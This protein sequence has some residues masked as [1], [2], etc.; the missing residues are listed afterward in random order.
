MNSQLFIFP[1]PERLI[2]HS[3]RM[4]SRVSEKKANLVAICI[5]LVVH[6]LWEYQNAV[7]TRMASGSLHARAESAAEPS[8]ASD[9]ST[10]KRLRISRTDLILPSRVHLSDVEQ[11]RITQWVSPLCRE[12]VVLPLDRWRLTKTECLWLRQS[13]RR[14]FW[15]LLTYNH[16]WFL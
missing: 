15:R 11:L 2:W 7:R 16:I 5:I 1:F 9:F 10:H 13:Y 3:Q 6:E 12:L 4:S 8:F 14:F